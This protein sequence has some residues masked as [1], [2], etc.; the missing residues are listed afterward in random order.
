MR[1]ALDCGLN[2]GLAQCDCRDL[3]LGERVRV[4]GMHDLA[5]DRQLGEH[6]GLVGSVERKLKSGLYAVRTEIGVA[7]LPKKNL[8]KLAG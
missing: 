6:I 7:N 8:D 3:R 1:H 4:N 5:M 2:C